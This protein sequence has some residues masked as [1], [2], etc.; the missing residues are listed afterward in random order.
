MFEEV[1][2]VLGGPLWA[3]EACTKLLGVHRQVVVG[4]QLGE[5]SANLMRKGHF[6]M[7]RL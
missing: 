3:V 1:H 7:G 6:R 2:Q 5:R 4:V